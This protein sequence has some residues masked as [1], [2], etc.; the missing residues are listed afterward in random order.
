[1]QTQQK[2]RYI[3]CWLPPLSDDRDGTTSTATTT[4]A[5]V[6]FPCCWLLIDPILFLP[7][8]SALGFGGVLS[9][10]SKV[11]FYCQQ[12][13]CIAQ[14]RE[15]ERVCVRARECVPFLAPA[16][17]QTNTKNKFVSF[18]HRVNWCVSPFV[19]VSEIKK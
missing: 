10:V 1:V 7:F 5:H 4:P 17:K 2:R 13:V 11:L 15:R 19:Q 16:H 8:S 3:C 9:S 6:S 14:W 12:F 18:S